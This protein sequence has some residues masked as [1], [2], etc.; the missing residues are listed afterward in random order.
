MELIQSDPHQV[1]NI[2]RKDR[3][4]QLNSH[5]SKQSRQPFL[6]C[7]IRRLPFSARAGYEGQK[8][9]IWQYIDE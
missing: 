1:L 3:Q 9:N 7:I 5:K 8:M 2:K 4:V 6:M